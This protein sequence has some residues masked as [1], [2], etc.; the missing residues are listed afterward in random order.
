MPRFAR[1]FFILL[2]SAAGSCSSEQLA[3]KQ[4]E[5]KDIREPIADYVHCLDVQ[6]D[7]LVNPAWSTKLI[8][9]RCTSPGKGL[10][11]VWGPLP[12]QHPRQSAP[13]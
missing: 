5:K 12:F 6:D 8:S 1:I 4:V 7:S 11:D 13:P 3:Q 2:A 10:Q 9:E